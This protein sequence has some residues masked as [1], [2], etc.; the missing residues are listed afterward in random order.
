MRTL[1]HHYAESSGFNDDDYYHLVFD[2]DSATFTVVH[3]W[4]YWRPKD[5]D[6]GEEHF[7]LKELKGRDPAIYKMTVTLIRTKLFS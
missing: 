4:H 6:Q 7:T 2:E 3:S 5:V 1:I